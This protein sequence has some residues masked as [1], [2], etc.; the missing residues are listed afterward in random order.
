M[1][2]IIRLTESDLVTLVNRVISE[3]RGIVKNI[4]DSVETGD[5]FEVLGLDNKTFELKL[6]DVSPR[7][8]KG[9]VGT[10]TKETVFVYGPHDNQISRADSEFNYK[11]GL[12][13]LSVKIRGKKYNVDTKGNIEI[14][15][16]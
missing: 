3:Q 10:D 8:I 13:V 2:K 4:D 15:Y 5:I 7:F 16:S 9:L 12:T 6:T 1:K 14:K 11:N